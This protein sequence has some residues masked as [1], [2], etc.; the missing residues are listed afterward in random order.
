MLIEK[1]S[2]NQRRILHLPEIRMAEGER[3]NLTILDPLAEWTVD[4]A[5]FKSGSRNTPF[6]GM[7]LK[8]R[9]LGIVNNG[10]VSWA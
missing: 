2:V 9:P 1:F 6:G 10:L 7:R 5:V 4:P 3:A 8:G